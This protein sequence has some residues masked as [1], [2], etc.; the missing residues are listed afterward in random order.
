MSVDS[1]TVETHKPTCIDVQQRVRSPVVGWVVGGLLLLAQAPLIIEHFCNMLLR[2]HYQFAVMLPVGVGLLIWRGL[3]PDSSEDSPAADAE[4]LRFSPGHVLLWVPVLLMSLG[5]LVMA[6]VYRSPWLGMLAFLL[7][8]LGILLF[9]GG[10]ALFRRLWPA[11]LLLW[12]ALPLPQNLDVRLIADLRTITTDW[13]S[14]V[15]DEFG[16]MHLVS[17]NVIQLPGKS[18]F[19]ADACTGIHSLFV[20]LAAALFIGLWLGR[21]MLHTA[22]LMLGTAGIVLVENVSRIC[23]IAIANSYGLD[24]SEGWQHTVL[25]L[26]LFALSLLFILSADSLL[27][28]L[29]F[30]SPRRMLQTMRRL[31]RQRRMGTEFDHETLH[32]AV[33]PAVQSEVQERAIKAP[34]W[35]SLL[36]FV[37][38]FLVL[39]AMQLSWMPTRAEQ[40]GKQL[41]KNPVDFP[42][43]GAEALPAEWNGWRR[44]DYQVSKRIVEDPLGEHSQAWVYQRDGLQAEISLDYPY[45][46]LH[47]L[48]SCYTGFGWEMLERQVVRTEAESSGPYVTASMMRPLHGYGFLIYSHYDLSG[49]CDVELKQNLSV[50]QLLRKRTDFGLPWFQIQLLD[51][52]SLPVSAAEQD[53]LRALFLELR[54]RMVRMC[55]QT[56]NKGEGNGNVST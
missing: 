17:G 9:V 14:A 5:I 15:L 7:T 30:L 19:I 39:G 12:V 38:A 45:R 21:P 55:L 33:S 37:L 40:L 44:V 31:R 8:T 51:T 52:S 34:Y 29:H 13:S 10:I 47:D 6:T 2:P 16:V 25:G 23:A 41:K 28:F 42:E 49:K 46:S 35:L 3:R 27:K 20:L 24:W 26:V 54:A 4:P 11:W 43:F 36:P 50:G 18:L 32:A 22:L 56:V 1:V 48:T 53:E